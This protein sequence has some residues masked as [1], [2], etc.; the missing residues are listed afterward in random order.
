MALLP[1]VLVFNPSPSCRVENQHCK[2][3][4]CNGLWI[5]IFLERFL[6]L[7]SLLIT[8]YCELWA[9]WVEEE[10]TSMLKL[11]VDIQSKGA[12]LFGSLQRSHLVWH[13]PWNK[14]RPSDVETIRSSI[15]G[16][17]HLGQTNTDKWFFGTQTFFRLWPIVVQLWL[18]ALPSFFFEGFLEHFRQLICDFMNWYLWLQAIEKLPLIPQLLEIV[19]LLYTGVSRFTTNIFFVNWESICYRF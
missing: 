12:P 1:W 2:W 19:G 15:W 7:P 14:L 8:C 16:C 4:C 11:C 6:L 5:D 9:S 17:S 13:H 10:M 18:W 3:D